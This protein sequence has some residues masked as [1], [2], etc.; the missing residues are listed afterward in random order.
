MSA[1]LVSV[2][3]FWE[4]ADIL[5]QQAK[6]YDSLAR[7]C[8]R[9]ELKPVPSALVDEL[10]RFEGWPARWEG[11]TGFYVLFNDGNRAV[12]LI[13]V[14]EGG[15]FIG[16]IKGA[17]LVDR[18]SEVGLDHRLRTGQESDYGQATESGGT[19]G[20]NP[21]ALSDPLRQEAMMAEALASAALAGGAI[22]MEE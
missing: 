16:G 19:T 4:R 2:E 18:T 12:G 10:P 1:S 5:R 7:L 3:I 20:H 14:T 17:G 22:D 9:Y 15:M 11:R 21:R 8:L 6:A 13:C